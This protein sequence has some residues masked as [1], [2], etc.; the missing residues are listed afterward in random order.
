MSSC[1]PLSLISACIL[2]ISATLLQAAQGYPSALSVS[3][4]VLGVTSVVHHSRLDTWWKWDAWRALDYVG[5]AC[6]AI[7]ATFYHAGSK[8]WISNCLF[9]VVVTTL[10]WTEYVPYNFVPALHACMHIA[11]TL[12]TTYLLV[13]DFSG[14]TKNE[15]R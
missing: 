6:F 4:L 10:I 7:V 8:V 2:L 1:S 15:E 3:F 13:N 14:E 5:T 11:V 12:C 9:A